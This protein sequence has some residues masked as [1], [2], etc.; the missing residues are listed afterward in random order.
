LTKGATAILACDISFFAGF[1]E[2]FL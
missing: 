1:R 2:S